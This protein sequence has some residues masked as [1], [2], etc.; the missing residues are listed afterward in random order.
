MEPKPPA[1]PAATPA[2]LRPTPRSSGSIDHARRTATFAYTAHRATGYGCELLRNR[3]IM[4]LRAS[5]WSALHGPL[6]MWLRLPRARR[7]PRRVDPPR[8]ECGSP[9]SAAGEADTLARQQGLVGG[10]EA[11][12]L[13]PG[14]GRPAH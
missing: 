9:S 8:L 5:G 11:G 2:P 13:P 10:A 7:E 6:P 1:H 4:F 12:V 14:R 3:L